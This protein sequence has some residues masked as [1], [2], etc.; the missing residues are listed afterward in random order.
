MQEKEE[1]S[2]KKKEKKKAYAPRSIEGDSWPTYKQKHTEEEEEGKYPNAAAVAAAWILINGTQWRN[3][4]VVAAR[5]GG[6]LPTYLCMRRR[7][8]V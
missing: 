5:H 3:K 7:H 4:L 2:K 8:R 1:K 6:G